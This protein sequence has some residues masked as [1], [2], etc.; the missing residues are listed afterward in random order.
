MFFVTI[1]DVHRQLHEVIVVLRVRA[2]YFIDTK[3]N[4]VVRTYFLVSKSQVENNCLV[5]W[6]LA[7]LLQLQCIALPNK[8]N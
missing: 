1:G 3:E 4:R 7:F 6:F 2:S 8:S 5:V